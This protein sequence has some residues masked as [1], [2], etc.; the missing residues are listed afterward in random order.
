MIVLSSNEMIFCKGYEENQTKSRG[1]RYPQMNGCSSPHQS[2][3]ESQPNCF[4]SQTVLERAEKTRTAQLIP[5]S[6][7]K[8]PQRSRRCTNHN[9]RSIVP[10]S[11]R[12]GLPARLGSSLPY[13]SRSSASSSTSSCYQ[14]KI[15]V[16]GTSIYTQRY[17]LGLL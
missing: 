16:F 10:P 5:E 3:H 13:W 12:P 7:N 17:Y 9:V 2:S 14:R 8:V 11:H 1:W 4:M 15:D 6:T